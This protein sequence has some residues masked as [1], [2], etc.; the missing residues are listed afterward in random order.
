MRKSK[1]LKMIKMLGAILILM[2]IVYNIMH[3]T[4][5]QIDHKGR[6][7]P[8]YRDE[9]FVEPNKLGFKKTGALMNI[10]GELPVGTISKMFAKF[11]EKE[12]A[13]IYKNT[14]NLTEV[15]LKEYYLEN[16]NNIDLLTY[17]DE[18]ESFINLVNK[19]RDIN[20]NFEEDY[21]VCEFEQI[22]IGAIRVKCSFK[23]GYS[24]EG[25]LLGT[26]TSNLKVRY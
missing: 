12:I 8:A 10:G 17:I 26:H 6:T 7:L 20:C 15:Q 3:N 13:V 5:T 21:E 22:E 24:L 16:I 1:L 2:I 14:K 9:D 4:N 18:E 25:K 19:L 11:Y 23:N